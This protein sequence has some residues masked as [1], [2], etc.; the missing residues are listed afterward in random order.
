MRSFILTILVC[1]TGAVAPSNAEDAVQPYQAHMKKAGAAYEAQDWGGLNQHLDA[2]QALRPYSLYVWK[3]RILARQL[4]GRTDEALALA[5]TIAQRGLSMSVAG[6][7]ALDA[8]TANPQFA[9]IAEAMAANMA[10]IGDAVVLTLYD[11]P[12]LLPEAYALGGKGVEIIGSVRT[13]KILDLGAAFSMESVAKAPGGVFDIELRGKK[14]WAAVNNQLAYENAGAEDSFAA[15]MIFDLKTGRT[16]RDIRMGES[17]ALFGDLEVAKNGTAYASDSLT[18]RIFRLEKKSDA[19]DVLAEDPRFAN[20]QGIAL[21]Q[22]KKRLFVADYLAGLFV[23]DIKTGAVTAIENSVN[24]HLGGIDG[25][26]LYKG[27]LIGIQNGTAPQRIIR[28]KLNHDATEAIG[29]EV[30]AQNLDEWNEPTH[31][32]ISGDALK[33]IAT[34][35]WPSYDADWNL[36]DG[37]EPQPVRIMAVDLE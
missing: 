37:A 31:G 21:D 33:Y 27:D 29:F 24:A 1:V 35:N 3:N 30:L 36:R 34:S 9:P 13:G 19:F 14:L 12:N 2:A 15:I 4:D 8:L 10:P 26:Y 32:A 23:I 20:L 16:V 25:L 28:I 17:D 7:E 6:H 22:K 5:D 11:Q 18:P